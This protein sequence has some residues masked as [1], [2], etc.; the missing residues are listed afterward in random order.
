[1]SG[2]QFVHLQTYSRKPNP[3]GQYVEQ[4]L[5][6]L[7]RLPEF[8]LHVD[9]PAPPRCID[10]L[11]TKDLIQRHDKMIT[12]A[13]VAVKVKGKTHHRSIRKDRHTL[14]TVVASYPLTWDQIRGNPQEERALQKWEERN[15]RFFKAMFGEH[16]KA[17]YS[18]V[19]EDHPHLHIYALPET[20]PGVDAT[21]LHPGKCAKADA[22]QRAREEGLS[23]REAVAIGNK[24][25]KD[26]M[27][28]FQDDYYKEVGEPSGLLRIGP[29]RQRLSRKDYL[30]QKHAAR[31]R[32]ESVLEERSA[33]LRHLED[34]VFNESEAL[35]VKSA[36]LEQVEQE[37]SLKSE[38][39]L[40]LDARLT[41]LSDTIM[42][43]MKRL[44][45]IVN[46]VGKILGTG[47][48]EVI[49]DGLD[50]LEAAAQALRTE[51][52]IGHTQP[53]GENLE[54]PGGF[55]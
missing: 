36:K 32:S 34:Q 2:P 41:K 35:H 54:G 39:L 42:D 51:R 12:D 4:I 11:S 14:M 30:A 1:M 49:S 13:R 44:R 17:T 5:G 37:I 50:N 16:Y 20:V 25:L 38:K 28:A 18:H 26:A 40:A 21:T 24:A 15:V 19:D 45:Q 6:E 46:A 22:E 31:L 55:A 29:K 48:F 3:A 43:H 53:G 7:A 52:D 27:R 10:G 8:S 9:A 23:A 47:A 33:E